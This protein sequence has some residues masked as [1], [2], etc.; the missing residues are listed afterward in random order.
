MGR[1]EVLTIDID[2]MTCAGC[3]G[4][5]ERAIAAVQ[6]VETAEVNL[7]THAG[8]VVLA[9]DAGADAARRVSGA[10]Q[11]AGY[12]AVPVRVKLGIEG[13]TCAGCAARVEQA[14]AGAPG[15][16]AAQV[17]FADGTA[18]VTALSGDVVPL[19]AAVEAVGY[20][21]APVAEGGAKSDRQAEETEALRRRFLL[22]AA[23]TLPVFVLEMGG[24]MVPAFHHWVMATIGTSVSWGV[25]FVLASLVLIGPGRG[26]YAK[27]IPALFRG[28][29]DMNSLVVLGT[30]A[31]WSYSTVALFAPGLMPEGAQ[32]V[33]FEAAAVIVTLILA[34]RWMEARAKGRTGEAIRKLVALRPAT[35]LVERGGDAVEVAVE[36]IR[37][38]EVLRIRPGERIAVDG[39]VR[40]GVS[41]VDE[42]M[43]TGEPMPVEK[44]K[45][46]VLIGGTV[47]G[48][49]A[50][51]MRATAVGSET[52]LARIIAMVEEAQ[53]ARL[54][55]QD[56]VN[57]I[58]LWFVPAVMVVA[59]VT[60]LAWLIW[61]PGLSHALVA[62]V[63]VLII[64]CP[65]A[66]G[67]A[68]P[69]S[70]MV[71]TGRAAELGVLFRQGDALQALSGVRTVA[72]DK[73][74]TLT[75]GRPDVTDIAA[76]SGS[77]DDL[78]ALAAGV[79]ALSEHPLGG[80]VVR[81]AKER[82]LAL[83][84]AAGVEALPGFG[85]V[86]SVGARRVAVGNARLMAREGAEGFDA[87]E[88]FAAQGKTV[89]LVAIDG[90]AAGVIAVAD[91]VKPG[92]KAAVAALK[93]QGLRVVMVSGDRAVVARAVGADV[94]VDEVIAEV[95]PEG[96]VSAVKALE[97]PVAFVGDGINDAPALAVAEVG[98]AIGTGTDVAVESA[99]VVLMSGDPGGVVNA[100]EVSRRTMRNI[101]EN[102]IWAFGYNVLLI[103]VAAGLAYPFGG[104]MLSPVL[105]AGAMAL[106]SVLV[107]TNALRL[108]WVP[109]AMGVGR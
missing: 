25:Q 29:P 80:A 3:V 95:L 1:H 17:N 60:V 81:A 48:S 62:G 64:A 5:A 85:V 74:G 83:P 50:L 58:T 106:S 57:R 14:L 45:G 107:L 104:W 55:V 90:V 68:V 20:G 2:G 52:M 38:G 39:V 59:L 70:I 101:R 78:L 19:V 51:R 69:V 63:A 8:R 53:G 42:S 105:A 73:T 47:N 43:V 92:A 41:H 9:P 30:A 67:L 10:L 86:G 13:M 6:G 109:Q 36:E 77:E 12:P 72:F 56:L 44:G 82:G 28:A 11:A 88:A 91:R 7:A 108:R 87:A 18:R 61:G 66:M 79:E 93:R 65:C 98:I 24:H 89:A 100:L 33:Y 71:G 34:G 96:K 37:R 27:G 97:G 16:L 84:Q 4:R 15:V 23:L 54:P 103:P 46:A 21:A 76:F 75:E 40:E 94:G 31:A 102:L 26:F 32:A 99:D 22:A 35:A 49:G